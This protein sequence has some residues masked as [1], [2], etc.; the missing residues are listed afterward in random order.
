M[1]KP[2]TVQWF[3]SNVATIEETTAELSMAEQGAYER[4]RLH[5]LKFK[6]PLPSDKK[7]LYATVGATDSR[8]RKAVDAVVALKFQQGNDGMLHNALCDEELK[9]IEGK[10]AV[11]RSAADARWGQREQPDS[12]RSNLKDA[13]ASDK[14]QAEGNL[15]DAF[16]LSKELKVKSEGVKEVKRVNRKEEVEHPTPLEDVLETKPYGPPTEEEQV[17]P[18]RSTPAERLTQEDTAH[19]LQVQPEA[20]L[21]PQAAERLASA[22]PEVTRRAYIGH[23]LAQ[24]VLVEAIDKREVQTQAGPKVTY[25][26]KGA[27]LTWDCAFEE[28]KFKVGDVI[29]FDFRESPYGKR[30]GRVLA[31]ERVAA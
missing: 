1:S 2:D 16:A 6:K 25:S 20:T 12:L 14:L 18:D 24:E 28:P 3:L 19:L 5:Y 10:V 13:F 31:V 30:V 15:L 23:A 29:T 17:G 4:L 9:R 27:G 21:A 8:E 22:P 7:R 11:R 26:F